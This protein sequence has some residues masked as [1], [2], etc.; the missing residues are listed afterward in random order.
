MS[1]PEYNHQYGLP[2]VTV[3]RKTSNCRGRRTVVD[4]LTCN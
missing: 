2:A 1:A 4:R 3:T